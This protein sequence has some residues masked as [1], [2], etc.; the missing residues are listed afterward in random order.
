MEAS[1]RSEILAQPTIASVSVYR[2]SG[3]SGL[4]VPRTPPPLLLTS[5]EPE[6]L[7]LSASVARDANIARPLSTKRATVRKYVEHISA[8]LRMHSLSPRRTSRRHRYG[9]CDQQHRFALRPLPQGQRSFRPIPCQRTIDSA[10][11][12]A[13]MASGR[14][15]LRTRSMARRKGCSA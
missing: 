8:K 1:A 14:F 9:R 7:P 15:R 11:R 4:G 12:S 6:V 5:R 3:A 13:M 10:R 2:S